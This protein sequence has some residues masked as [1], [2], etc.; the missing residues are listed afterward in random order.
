MVVAGVV[1]LLLSVC[2]SVC[3]AFQAIGIP[4]CQTLNIINYLKHFAKIVK[5]L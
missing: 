3:L 2:L 4:K 1:K 5:Y